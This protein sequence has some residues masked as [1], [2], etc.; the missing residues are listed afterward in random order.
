[1]AVFWNTV[2]IHVSI[3]PISD[4]RVL[5]M[6]A[7]VTN[8]S[9]L[10]D[11]DRLWIILVLSV[12]NN[13]QHVLTHGITLFIVWSKPFLSFV[14]L[15]C[16]SSTQKTHRIASVRRRPP[17]WWLKFFVWEV[18]FDPPVPIQHH[19]LLIICAASMSL[20]C[21]CFTLRL[22]FSNNVCSQTKEPATRGIDSWLHDTDSHKNWSWFAF[23][24]FNV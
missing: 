6:C 19:S 5:Y 7:V 14:R 3:R 16:T 8:K 21:L 20:C 15:H 2:Y 24:S 12:V 22:C 4:L 17:H 23:E 18:G 9:T 1:M 11:D 10:D 13:V